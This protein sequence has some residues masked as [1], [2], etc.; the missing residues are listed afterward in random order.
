MDSAWERG[1]SHQFQC[2]HCWRW[3]ANPK[4]PQMSDLPVA[5][6]QLFKLAF[7]SMGMDCFGPF[8]LKIGQRVEKRLGIVWKLLTTRCVYLDILSSIDSDSFLMAFRRFVACK[9]TPFEL[10]SD[11]GT[12]FKEGERDLHEAFKTVTMSYSCS[13]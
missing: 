5:R 4:I 12:N 3:R 9:G 7:Y 8:S 10:W 1:C 13:W 6:L 11:Q 2:T